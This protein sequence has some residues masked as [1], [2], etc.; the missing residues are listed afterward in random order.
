MYAG[1][2]NEHSNGAK[3]LKAKYPD[4]LFVVQMDVTNMQQIQ[5]V[6]QDIVVAKTGMFCKIEMNSKNSASLFGLAI[7]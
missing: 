6:Y 2:L 1:C 5:T 7:G 3:A 4:R